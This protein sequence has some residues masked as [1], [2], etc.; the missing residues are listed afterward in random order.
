MHD[1]GANREVLHTKPIALF[2][3]DGEGVLAKQDFLVAK[4][5]GPDKKP[6]ELV[7]LDDDEPPTT[8]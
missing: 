4:L 1:R 8:L 5:F 2:F 6:E 3:F 7:E